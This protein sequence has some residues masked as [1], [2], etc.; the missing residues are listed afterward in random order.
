MKWSGGKICFAFMKVKI[1]EENRMIGQMPERCST[2]PFCL[3]LLWAALDR[4][5]QH[6]G[7]CAELSS[8][9]ASNNVH[10]NILPVNE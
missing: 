9:N 3:E 8:Q 10:H 5:L 1:E 2:C 7:R 6:L 4:F